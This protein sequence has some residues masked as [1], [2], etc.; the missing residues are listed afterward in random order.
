MYYRKDLNDKIDEIAEQYKDGMSITELS[1]KYDASYPTIKTKLKQVYSEEE[2]QTI[3]R[4]NRKRSLESKVKT[5]RA[6]NTSGYY[7]VYKSKN[8]KLK[9]GFRW[10]YTYC[11][12]DGDRYNIAKVNLK[13]LERAV[14]RRGLDWVKL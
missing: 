8:D 2:I 4:K 3:N 10:M 5:S 7:R 13:D 14:K 9:Q 1:K 11:D 12:E 6:T